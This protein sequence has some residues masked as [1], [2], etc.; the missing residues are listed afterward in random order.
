MN[1]EEKIITQINSYNKGLLTYSEMLTNISHIV[2]NE[3]PCVIECRC[4]NKGKW[5]KLNDLQYTQ[6][7][8]SEVLEI[9]KHNS[10]GWQYRI[11]KVG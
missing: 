3:M 9:L 4:G 10:L 11:K 2:Q 8:A 1:V 7:E 5:H 6:S